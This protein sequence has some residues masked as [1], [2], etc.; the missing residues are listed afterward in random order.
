MSTDKHEAST[1]RVRIDKWLWAARFFK[2]RS[3]AKAAIEGGQV[4]CDGQRVK[5]SR[6][7]APG[8]CLRIRQG[9]EHKTIVVQAVSGARGPASVAQLLYTETEESIAERLDHAEQRKAM[10]LAHPDHK[11]NKKERRQIHRFQSFTG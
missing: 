10:N 5:V 9:N 4:H 8:M 1:T 6:D 7:V 2:T 11:P 3:L